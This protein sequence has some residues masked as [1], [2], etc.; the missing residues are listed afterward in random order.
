MQGITSGE[1]TLLIGSAIFAVVFFV[2]V[3]GAIIFFFKRAER[4]D[5]G[6]AARFTEKSETTAPQNEDSPTP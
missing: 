1:M 2:A 3:S 6:E 4:G 5:R